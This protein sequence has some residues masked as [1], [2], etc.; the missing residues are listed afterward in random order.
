MPGLYKIGFTHNSPF[1]RADDLSCATG[2]P[3]PFEVLGFVC[4]GDP[5]RLEAAI[6]QHFASIRSPGREF[7]KGPV[8]IL[9]DGLTAGEEHEAQCDVQIAPWDYLDR[10][11]FYNGKA[12]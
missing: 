4:I 7:F 2:V 12:A 6:H 11:D 10:P 3:S 1:Q 9:W 5:Q 8:G